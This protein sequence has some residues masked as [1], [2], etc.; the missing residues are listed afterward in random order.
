[1]EFLVFDNKN[2]FL[3]H[4]LVSLDTSLLVLNQV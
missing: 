1:M 4:K 2:K 3:T